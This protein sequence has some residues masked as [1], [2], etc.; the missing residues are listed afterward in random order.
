MKDEDISSTE[1]KKFTLNQKNGEDIDLWLAGTIH[2]RWLGR[3]IIAIAC[4]EAPV[5]ANIIDIREKSGDY[6]FR[7]STMTDLTRAGWL[8]ILK[9]GDV[10]IT[11]A[12]GTFHKTQNGTDVMLTRVWAIDHGKKPDNDLLVGN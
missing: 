12:I 9:I 6:L 2:K 3:D 5:G 8:I 7:G 11:R 1:W 4:Y 10:T